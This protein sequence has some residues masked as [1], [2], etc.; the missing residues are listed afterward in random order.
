ML[1]SNDVVEGGKRWNV[2][3][4]LFDVGEVRFDAAKVRAVGRQEKDVVA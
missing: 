1:S 4:A 2:L 3:A